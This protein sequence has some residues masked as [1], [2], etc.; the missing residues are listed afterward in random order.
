MMRR[1]HTPLCERW[2]GEAAKLD[3]S[4]LPSYNT[5]ER[6]RATLGSHLDY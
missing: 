2:D 1:R 6:S 3:R 5:E 4:Q